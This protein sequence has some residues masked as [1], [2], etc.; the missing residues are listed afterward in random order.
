MFLFDNYQRYNLTF[1]KGAGTYLYSDSGRKYLD[2]ASGISVTNFGHSH[3]YILSKVKQQ[4]D[5][6]WHTSNLFMSDLGEAL[7]ERISRLSFN[8]KIFFCNSGAEANEAAIKLARIYNNNIFGGKRPR[9][10][11]MLN[12]FHGRTY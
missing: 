12:S 1:V 2:C 5:K 10:I 8:G 6:L 7:A 11:T 3:P 4:I 9:I